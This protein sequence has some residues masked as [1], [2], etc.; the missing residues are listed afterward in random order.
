MC[1]KAEECVSGASGGVRPSV[2]RG[3][4]EHKDR[5]DGQDAA[6]RG[7]TR[8]EVN[9]GSFGDLCVGGG[10]LVSV[11]CACVPTYALLTPMCEH[12]YVSACTGWGAHSTKWIPVDRHFQDRSLWTERE[13][14]REM[15]MR[16]GGGWPM[17]SNRDGAAC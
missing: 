3:T 15:M 6:L 4:K 12:V 13:K 14:E 8:S 16:V 5:L 11:R 10:F 2:S 7:D 9:I 1:L 17:G